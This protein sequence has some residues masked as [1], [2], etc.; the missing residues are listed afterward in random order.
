VSR[1]QT[2]VE[3]AA[4]KEAQERVWDAFRRWGYVQAHLDPLEDL[5]PV[6]MPELDLRGP[7]AEAARRIYCG[8]IGVEFMHIADRETRQWVQARMESEAPQV[9]RERI[10]EC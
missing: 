8:T 2:V 1:Q 3:S 10:L 9:D 6:A 5:Q 7:E 4:T